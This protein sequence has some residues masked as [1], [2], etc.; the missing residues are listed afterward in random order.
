MGDYISEAYLPNLD[1]C[2]S[3]RKIQ[4]LRLG[5]S[6]RG[7]ESSRRAD[8]DYGR[9]REKER[10]RIRVS[11]SAA[12]AA[13]D[14]P[15]SRVRRCNSAKADVTAL[16]EW[17]YFSSENRVFGNC[18]S[19]VSDSSFMIKAHC[20]SV[21]NLDCNVIRRLNKRM[22]AVSD[23]M[24]SMSISHCIWVYGKSW[25]DDL[26][27][28]SGAGRLEQ[29]KNWSF[30]FTEMMVN[31]SPELELQKESIPDTFVTDFSDN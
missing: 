18:R 20:C 22:R 29:S 19:W 9:K 30:S 17:H 6:E 27:W 7:H 25:L 4:N 28:K 1:L 10:R 15:V 14:T 16:V 12:S 5:G 24:M 11:D 13:A 21:E 26:E 8:T 23:E 2:I 31:L 3:C